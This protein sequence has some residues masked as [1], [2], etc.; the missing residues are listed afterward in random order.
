ME[1]YIVKNAGKVLNLPKQKPDRNLNQQQ[2]VDGMPLPVI[3]TQQA[4][5]NKPVYVNQRAKFSRNY[6]MSIYGVVRIAIIV[7]SSFLVLIL[8][9][10]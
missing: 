8:L 7:I 5:Q 10:H 6:C 4:N 3:V 1:K 9:N 2:S